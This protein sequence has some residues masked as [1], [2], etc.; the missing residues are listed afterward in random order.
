M[1]RRV[2]LR[3]GQ[4]AVSAGLLAYLVATVPMQE[5]AEALLGAQPPWVIGGLAA[6]LAAQ[7]IGALQMRLILVSQGV[8]FSVWQVAGINVIASFYGLFLPGSLAGGLIRWHHFSRPEGKRGPVLAAMMFSRG[9]EIVTMLG[10]GVVFWS[11]SAT[12]GSPAPVILILAFAL[13]ALVS[14]IL[15]LVSRAQHALLAATLPRLPLPRR[16]RDGLFEVSA[17]LAEFGRH[18]RRLHFRF[19]SLCIVRNAFAVAAFVCFARAVGISANFADLGWVRSAI[20]L[21]LILPISI[22]GVGVRD[23]SLVALLSP[24]G[25]SSSMALAFSFS[26]L[27][28]TLLIAIIGG[29]VEALRVYHGVAPGFTERATK[30]STHG[31]LHDEW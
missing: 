2:A 5:V 17:C 9:V 16:L 30:S 28:V 13:M 7:L 15:F 8:A 4:A 27:G 14:S 20:D 3:A 22:A 26:L 29:L 21:L 31:P 6:V 25:V 12:E 23:A 19:I 1:N 24:L 10:F 11:L 18:G